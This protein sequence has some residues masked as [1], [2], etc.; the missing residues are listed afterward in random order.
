LVSFSKLRG[1][2]L[3]AATEVALERRNVLVSNRERDGEDTAMLAAKEC[4][5]ALDTNAPA[6]FRE[7][8]PHVGSE[9]AAKVRPLEAAD[10]GRASERQWVIGV[11][12]DVAHQ[13]LQPPID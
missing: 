5:R 10:L 6:P 13:P 4:F 11:R 1:R 2:Q 12:R 9:E 3:L 8:N 7:A